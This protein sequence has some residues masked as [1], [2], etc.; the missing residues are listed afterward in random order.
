MEY[1]AREVRFRE[2]PMANREQRPNKEKKKPKK[3]KTK[4]VAS[5]QASPF[6][7]SRNQK[8]QAGKK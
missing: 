3:E 8:P 1:P 4:P 5:P 7:D 2:A 6:A